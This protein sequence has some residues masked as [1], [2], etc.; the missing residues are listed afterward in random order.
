V[1]FLHKIHKQDEH[2][3][4]SFSYFDI[5]DMQVKL[6]DAWLVGQVLY[7]VFEKNHL[8]LLLL[9]VVVVFESYFGIMDASQWAN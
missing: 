2:H 5:L 8:L 3:R 9:L 7:F 4:I 1:V 6:F